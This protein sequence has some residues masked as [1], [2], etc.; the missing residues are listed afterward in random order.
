MAKPINR[1]SFVISTLRKA[2]FRW[3]P[4][5]RVM[6]KARRD[7]GKYECAICHSIVGNRDIQMD[8]KEP[9][10]LVDKGF[11]TFD[12]YIERLFCD[13][14]GYQAICRTCHDIKT[15]EE[16][17]LRKIFKYS[18]KSLTQAKDSV[19]LTKYESKSKNSKKR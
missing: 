12:E 5:Y 8:H 14:D 3:P 15:K 11:T 7:R 1:K 17:E 10:L 19:T 16:N 2:S 18:T 13:E 9:V 6:V 4:R